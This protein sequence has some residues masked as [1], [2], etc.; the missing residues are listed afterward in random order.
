MTCYFRHLQSIFK[1]AGIEVTKEN[2]R[3]L[4]K[5]IRRIVHVER[6]NCS[7]TWREVKKLIA[8]NE[9]SFVAKLKEEWVKH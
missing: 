8:E 6:Q 4:D 3:D 7:A 5:I 2:K 1:H 9:G